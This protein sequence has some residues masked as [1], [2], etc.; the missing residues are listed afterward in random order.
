V[1]GKIQMSS[2]RASSAAYKHVAN[3]LMSISLGTFFLLHVLTVMYTPY[4]NWDVAAFITAGQMLINGARP[5][6]EIVEINFPMITYLNALPAAFSHLTQLPLAAVGLVYLFSLVIVTMLLFGKILKLTFAGLTHSH[7][8]FV[9]IIWLC[10][11][12]WTYWNGDFGQRE[13]LIF[14]F[15]APYVVLRHAR[16]TS[17]EISPWLSSAIACAAFC[18]LAIKPFFIL[19][20]FIVEAVQ[21]CAHRRFAKFISLETVILAFLIVLYAAHFY[22]F[23]GMSAF[24]DY[25]LGFVW[26]GN[27]AFGIGV[28]QVIQGLL[29]QPVFFVCC[30]SAVFL[31]FIF[32]KKMNSLVLLASCFGWFACC[33]LLLYIV[34]ARGWA[35]HLLP[36]YYSVFV[37]TTLA[38]LAVRKCFENK[39]FLFLPLATFALLIGLFFYYPGPSRLVQK[40]G[41][42]APFVF[43]RNILV[44]R[45]ESLTEPH[46]TVVFLNPEIRPGFPALTYTGRMPGIRFLTTFPIAWIFKNSSNYIPEKQWLHDEALFYEMLVQDVETL[47]PRLIF[48]AAND[49]LQGPA[50]YFKIPEYLRIKG[51]FQNISLRYDKIE[52]I[53]LLFGDAFELWLLKEE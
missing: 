25:W 12:L 21:V 47:R 17:V 30:M 49:N 35:Y 15:L 4:L 24:Y 6:V 1:W 34:Q 46:E 48:I 41:H 5:Y 14:L 7:I 18:G 45:I 29:K 10:C 27:A 8:C 51:F 43:P 36:F 32:L 22:F 26:R 39:Y 53:T 37:G 13:Q 11:S 42:I 23:T 19:P 2:F 9:Y 40:I 31:C 3:C 44:E 52:D 28:G 50:S 16:Y 38:F 33:S 20:L